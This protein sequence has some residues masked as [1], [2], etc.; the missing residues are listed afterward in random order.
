MNRL[1]KY[2]IPVFLVLGFLS[3]KKDNY[4]PP[5]STLNG[6]LVYKGEAIGVEYDRVPFELY[7]YG[8]GKIGSIAGTFAPDGTYSAL[9]FDGE[10]KMIIPIGQGPF[11]SKTIAAGKPDSIAVSVNGNKTMD[12]EVEP[13]YMIR[14]PQVSAASGKV[15]GNFKAEKIVTDATGKDIEQVTLYIGKTQFVSGADNIA[16]SNIAGSAITDPNNI[17]LNVTIP[18]ISP[19][20]NYVFARLSIKVA[21]VEDRIFSPVVKLNF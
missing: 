14:S 18:S 10:Y 4:D 19:T 8:F 9:L 6:K 17:S 21:G 15:T 20:Q 3:C 5:S 7:Q 16:L 13:F 11:K 2:I 1:C 12:I